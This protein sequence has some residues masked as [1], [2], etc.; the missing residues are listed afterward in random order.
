MGGGIPIYKVLIVED[1]DTIAREIQKNLSKWGL[2]SVLAEDFRDVTAVFRAYA[3]HLVLLDISLPF[4][5]GFYWCS[6]IRKSSKVPIIFLSSRTEKMDILMAVNMGGDDFLTKPVS[7]EILV[8]KIQAMLRRSYDYR[9]DTATL[10]FCGAAVD[11][12]AACVTH[13]G[14]KAQLT[15]NELKIL[16]TLLEN[17][18][19]I[20]SRE[21][22]MLRLWDSDSFVDE[23]TLTVNVN[24]LRKTL[25]SIG[26]DE[27]IITYK[28]QGYGING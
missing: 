5:S 16:T 1:D 2:D 7:M 20:T 3:P 18:N 4:Y 14:Q 15:K 23:N 9:P 27:C 24:R 12:A 25:A 22:L 19:A 17:K 26:M 21:E 8:A 10:S 13:E 28:G 11:I 6:E